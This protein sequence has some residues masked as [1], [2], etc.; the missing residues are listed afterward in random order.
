[1]VSVSSTLG[2]EKQGIASAPALV[3]LNKFDAA[4]VEEAFAAASASVRRHYQQ[5]GLDCIDCHNRPTHLFQLPNRAIDE[6]TPFDPEM[7]VA[8]ARALAA[9]SYQPPPPVSQDWLDLSAKVTCYL[10]AEFP[11]TWRIVIA[12]NAEPRMK[13]ICPPIP[14]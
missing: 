2:S 8:R 10:S 3:L 13:S 14:E 1:M 9:E 6:A 7:V 12:D 4:R 5:R 11:F